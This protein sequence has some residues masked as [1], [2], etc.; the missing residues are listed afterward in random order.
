MRHTFPSCSSVTTGLLYS[1]GG[2]LCY[3]GHLRQRFRQPTDERAQFLGGVEAQE[4]R[5]RLAVALGVQVH[6][7]FRHAGVRVDQALAQLEPAVPAA[8]LG[9]AIELQVYRHRLFLLPEVAPYRTGA[10][11]VAE[12]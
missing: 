9:R 10:G 1:I 8:R 12:R 3:R 7:D 4:D 5:R 6:V 2:L 11:E